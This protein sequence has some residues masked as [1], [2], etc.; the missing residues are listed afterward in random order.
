MNFRVYDVKESTDRALFT[1]DFNNILPS[2][3]DQGESVLTDGHG[4]GLFS[5]LGN[6]FDCLFS[7]NFPYSYYDLVS[8]DFGPLMSSNN[9][10][11]SSIFAL[12][13]DGE[14]YFTSFSWR[15]MK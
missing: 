2:G 9:W 4:F 11:V 7:L 5:Q 14:I 1:F 13:S 10:Q 6:D 12:D 15:D 3:S 8:F